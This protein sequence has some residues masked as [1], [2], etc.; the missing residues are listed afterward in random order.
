M[1][2]VTPEN[3]ASRDI[4]AL[5]NEQKDA[6]VIMIPRELAEN[7]SQLLSK[8]DERITDLIRYNSTEVVRRRV[9]AAKLRVAYGALLKAGETFRRY[10]KLHREKQTVDG[11]TKAQANDQM[12]DIMEQA[13]VWDIDPAEL[14]RP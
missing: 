5:L 12:A 3:T 8:Q 10:G 4:R 6:V 11:D 2:I 9:L 13:I 7:A 14:G 1:K